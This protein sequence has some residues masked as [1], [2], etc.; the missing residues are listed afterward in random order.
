[1]RSPRR[2]GIRQA[3]NGLLWGIGLFLAFVI[4]L[5]L[6]LDRIDPG[7]RDLEFDLKISRLRTLVDAEPQ[8]P[9]L[10]VLGSSRV[11]SGVDPDSVALASTQKPLVFNAG[12]TGGGPMAELLCLRRLLAS[13]I[14][15]TWIVAEVF[16]GILARGAAELTNA[17]YVERLDFSEMAALRKYVTKPLVQ[18]LEWAKLRLTACS[19]MRFGMQYRYAPSWTLLRNAANPSWTTWE[20]QT[21]GG[22]MTPPERLPAKVR[23]GMV[24]KARQAYSEGLGNFAVPDASDQAL[25]DFVELCRSENIGL[26]LVWLP[27]AQEFKNLYGPD[28]AAT[29]AVYFEKLHQELDV[30]YVNARNWIA[31]DGFLD[32][33]H[34]SASGA[35][36]FTRR[37]TREVVEP[38]VSDVA[39][40]AA[41]AFASRR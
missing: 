17:G 22:W 30:P 6:L 37:L 25:R 12:L 5:N 18:D 19:S 32:G 28:A 27:E 23:Q 21:A 9:L 8:R 39:Q 38:L 29:A 35:K 11:A 36:V 26:A 4:F 16:P 34:L 1:M 2:I 14:R 15:P 41:P 20:R 24:A 3:R 13:G 10:L 7:L 33:H 31:D 40:S